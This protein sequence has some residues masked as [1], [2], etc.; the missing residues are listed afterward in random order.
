MKK[1]SLFVLA[2][3]LFTNTFAQSGFYYGDEFVKLTPL[4]SAASYAISTAGQDL[5]LAERKKSGIEEICQIS[6]NIYYKKSIEISA[7]S[8]L[9]FF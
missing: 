6:E 2:I 5:L 3:L 4:P 9:C 8:R 7:I 1:I